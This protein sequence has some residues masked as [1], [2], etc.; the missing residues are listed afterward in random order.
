MVVNLY[1]SLCMRI[2]KSSQVD[3][4]VTISSML[5]PTTPDKLIYLAISI[6]PILSSTQS[7]ASTL[8]IRLFR[9]FTTSTSF[10][11]WPTSLLSTL[12]PLGH[13]KQLKTR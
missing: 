5:C 6:I 4:T 2:Y 13:P 10:G 9:S 7:K 11:L 1:S 12:S 3:Y 8:S